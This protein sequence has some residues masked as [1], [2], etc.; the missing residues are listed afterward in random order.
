MTGAPEPNVLSSPVSVEFLDSTVPKEIIQRKLLSGT[1]V[2][3]VSIEF[4][5][6]NSPVSMN[7]P[8]IDFAQGTEWSRSEF[9]KKVEEFACGLVEFGVEKSDRIG[10][11]GDNTGQYVIAMFAAIYLGVTFSPIKPANGVFETIEQ[12]KNFQAKVLIVGKSRVPVLEKALEKPEYKSVLD[13]LKLIVE[14]ETPEPDSLL[15]DHKVPSQTIVSYEQVLHK[16]SGNHL[17]QIPYFSTSPDDYFMVVYTSGTTGLPKGAIH[18]HR[19]MLASMDLSQSPMKF[20]NSFWYPLGH[21]SGISCILISLFNGSTVVFLPNAELE[22]NLSAIEQ[23]KVNV[24]GLA[25]YHISQL[26][27]NDYHHQYSLESL[28]MIAVGGCKCPVHL[29][30]AV[31]KKYRVAVSNGYGCTEFLTGVRP[32]PKAINFENVGTLVPGVEMK[33]VDLEDRNRN[34]SNNQEGEICFRGPMCFVGYLNNEL[35]TK[36]AIDQNGWYHTGDVGYYDSQGYLY[37]VDRVKELI[38]YKLWSIAPA[39]IEE[40]LLKHHSVKEVCVVGVKHQSDGQ[41]IRAYVQL[42][43]EATEVTEEELTSYVAD[44]MGYQKQLRGGVRFLNHIPRTS[45]GKVDRKYFR[46]LIKDEILA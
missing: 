7:Q 8:Q 2:W 1:D 26:V 29:L 12:L 45:I 30:R 44:N 31:E 34:L 28:K 21:L 20:R 6:E 40:F 23:H 37:I 17:K 15:L 38:K 14:M 18:T 19:S 39:E 42:A 24:T 41:L 33:I 46:N 35:A 16:G 4:G 5:V 25:P 27:S 22:T 11:F 10:F 13:K 9:E 32:N 36:E 3:F 43:P